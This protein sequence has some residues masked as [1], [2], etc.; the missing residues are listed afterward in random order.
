MMNNILFT[1][2]SK[3]TNQKEHI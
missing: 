3:Q 1:Q 2:T